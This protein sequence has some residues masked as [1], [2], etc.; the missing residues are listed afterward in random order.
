MLPLETGFPHFS[1]RG[2]SWGTSS[3]STSTSTSIGISL[4]CAFDA[5]GEAGVPRESGDGPTRPRGTGDP[6][7]AQ[8]RVEPETG[9]EVGNGAE[10]RVSSVHFEDDL[11]DPGQQILGALQNLEFL[12]FDVDLEDGDLPQAQL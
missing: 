2:G 11:P 10:F 7:V 12:P 6:P 5:G 1:Q 8:A 9:E 3:T 4:S